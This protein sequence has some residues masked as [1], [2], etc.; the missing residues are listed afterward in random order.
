[1]F[2]TIHVTSSSR[3]RD[4]TPMGGTPPTFAES[5]RRGVRASHARG[6]EHAFGGANTQKGGG[7][8]PRWWLSFAALSNSEVVRLNPHVRG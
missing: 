8:W 6:V 3:A 7:L 1:M 4:A 5:R 2:A